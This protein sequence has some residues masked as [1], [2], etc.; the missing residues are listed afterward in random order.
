MKLTEAT[1]QSVVIERPDPTPEQPQHLCLDKGYDYDAVRALLET[2]G[3]TAHIRTRG[4]ETAAKTQLP[5]LPRPALGRRAH[6]FLDEPFPSPAHPLGEESR[7][8]PRHAPSRFRLYH[9]SRCQGYRIGSKSAREHG[10]VNRAS[11][12]VQK[13]FGRSHG[14]LAF[15]K[16]IT[17]PPSCFNKGRVV[18][19]PSADNRRIGDDRVAFSQSASLPAGGG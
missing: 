14:D 8:L 18:D 19:I 1:L 3:Y 7:E 13:I 10:L 4:E 15:T 11:D 5:G 12:F 6:P 9:L 2:Y 17:N 16:I